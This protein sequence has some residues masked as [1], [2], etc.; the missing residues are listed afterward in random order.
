MDGNTLASTIATAFSRIPQAT[1]PG[2]RMAGVTPSSV[3]IP[4]SPASPTGR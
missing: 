2:V 4:A 3:A 1:L